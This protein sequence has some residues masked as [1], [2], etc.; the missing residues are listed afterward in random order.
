MDR[1]K[2]VISNTEDLKE[3]KGL[4]S[5]EKEYRFLPLP[6]DV[7]PNISTD[8]YLPESEKARLTP[9]QKTLYSPDQILAARARNQSWYEQV[10]LATVNFV[11]NV[12]FGLGEMA[13]LVGELGYYAFLFCSFLILFDPFCSILFHFIPFCSILFHFNQFCSIMF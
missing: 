13:G 3:E 5:A 7:R 8:V 4:I 6:K 12:L 9:F 1:P 11:P 2:F 10:G